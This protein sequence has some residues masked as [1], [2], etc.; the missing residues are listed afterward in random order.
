MTRPVTSVSKASRVA[1]PTP[2]S[3]F[4][5]MHLADPKKAPVR[6]D[7]RRKSEVGRMLRR[8]AGQEDL[9]DGDEDGGDGGG[10]VIDP[11]LRDILGLGKSA[12]PQGRGADDDEDDDDGSGSGDTPDLGELQTPSDEDGSDDGSEDEDVSESRSS[13]SRRRGRRSRGGA[14]SSARRHH[15]HRASR[16]PSAALNLPPRGA[17]PLRTPALGYVSMLRGGGG[18]AG[19]DDDGF[20]Q[21]SSRSSGGMRGAPSAGEALLRARILQAARGLMG[22]PGGAGVAGARAGGSGGLLATRGNA[23]PAELAAMPFANYA[24][25]RAALR[26]DRERKIQARMMEMVHKGQMPPE[27]LLDEDL[28]QSSKLDADSYENDPDAYDTDELLG[29]DASTISS[30]D[31]DNDTPEQAS[32]RA[33]RRDRRRREKVRVLKRRKRQMWAKK[34][35]DV[36][37]AKSRYY[38]DMIDELVRANPLLRPPAAAADLETKRAFVD[39]ATAENMTRSKIDQMAR[40]I[41][42]VA[43]VL[44]NLGMI[45]GFLM[46]EGLSQAVDAELRKPEMQPV[47]AQ[48]A[49]KYLR[50]GPSSP[51]WGLAIMF[52]GTAGTVHAMNVRQQEIAQAAAGQGAATGPGS[53]K[54]GRIVSGAIKVFKVLGLGGGGGGGAAPPA[55]APEARPEQAS[56]AIAARYETQAAEAAGAAASR[57]PD[58]SA[59]QPQRGPGGP[60]RPASAARPPSRPGTGLS[61][62][63]ATRRPDTGLSAG[64]AGR[65]L[66]VPSSGRDSGS[67]EESSRAPWE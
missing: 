12:A 1:S 31:D 14:S 10:A 44:E 64:S 7:G 45:T 17:A 39:R 28:A 9:N 57:I 38:D 32:R 27:L 25:R 21:S 42:V 16:P 59:A 51:E 63:T 26:E 33:R 3:K 19:G 50:R 23:A 53:S 4:L 41:Y 24:E 34:R 48:L 61:A 20:S 47:I 11:K 15:R 40:W 2:R 46:L 13:E 65:P 37:A 54:L 56:A 43:V 6:G 18:G 52:L 8:P 30:T 67:E 29:S 66:S 5:F 36:E 55:G 49:R 22:A 58:R 62:A 60:A 35:R